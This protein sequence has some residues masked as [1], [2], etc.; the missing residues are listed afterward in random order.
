[1]IVVA[2][3]TPPPPAGTVTVAAAPF[4]ALLAACDR[5]AATSSCPTYLRAA[6]AAMHAA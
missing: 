3:P 2:A 6:V 5:L 4:Q 1:M